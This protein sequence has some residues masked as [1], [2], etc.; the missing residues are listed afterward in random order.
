[1]AIPGSGGTSLL[2]SM[3]QQQLQGNSCGGLLGLANTGS[4]PDLSQRGVSADH[5][6]TNVRIALPED[7]NAVSYAL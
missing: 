7:T 5:M 1:M 3:Q 6:Q 2:Q 4:L